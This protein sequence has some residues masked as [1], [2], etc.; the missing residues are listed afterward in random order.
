MPKLSITRWAEEDRPREKLLRKGRSSL[1][2]AEL[3]ATLISTGSANESAVDVAKNILAATGNDLNNLA[4]LSAEELMRFDGIGQ[5]KAVSIISALELGRRR[6]SS[7]YQ[8]KKK[9]VQPSHIYEYLKPDL[10]D[11][12]HEEFWIV[13][14][15][16]DNSVISKQAVSSGGV[17]GTV[18]DPKVIYKKALDKMASGIV[19]AHNHPS[20]NL[21]PSE[22][23]IRLTRKLKEAGMLLDIQFTDHIIFTDKGYFSF[24]EEGIL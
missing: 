23:D 9:I 19:V 17:S 16:R 7:E 15:R 5:A 8:E 18:A 12:T 20:G 3:I 6:N 4:K 14:L 24:A 2:N 22:A 13:L 21:Q 11:L 1:S 10:M